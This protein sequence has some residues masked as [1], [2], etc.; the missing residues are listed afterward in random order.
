MAIY[1]YKC[2]EC[3]AE[4]EVMCKFDERDDVLECSS[5]W[6]KFTSDER[7]TMELVI[8]SP[9]FIIKGF[10]EENGYSTILEE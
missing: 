1:N 7:L 4:K 8:S 10:S 3:G 2:T 6:R 5:H 9:G